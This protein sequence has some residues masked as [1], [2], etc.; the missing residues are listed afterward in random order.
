MVLDKVKTDGIMTT[1]SAVKSK[2][3]QPIPLGYCNVGVVREVGAGVSEFVKGDRVVSNGSHSD[4]V[5][6]PKTFVLRCLIQLQMKKRL[7]S[8]CKYR[9]ARY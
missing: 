4:V 8:R 1:Y 7:Y 9:F 2:L 3:N 5:N 6:V